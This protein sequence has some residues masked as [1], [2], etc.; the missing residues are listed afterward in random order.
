MDAGSM[1]DRSGKSCRDGKGGAVAAATVSCAGATVWTAAIVAATCA[2]PAGFGLAKR[3][4]RDFSGVAWF[5]AGVDAGF[6]ALGL[7][8]GL[9]LSGDATGFGGTLPSPDVPPD[10]GLRLAIGAA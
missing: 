8:V 7:R 5:F 9:G 4:L 2:G 6:A 1:A 10:V 3:G